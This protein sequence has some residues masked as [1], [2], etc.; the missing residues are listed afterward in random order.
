VLATPNQV[1]QGMVLTART[2]SAPGNSVAFSV[3]TSDAATIVAT[4]SGSTLS[5]GQDAAQIAPG[6]VVTI[7]GDDLSEQT[8]SAD[9]SQR[10]LPNTLAGVQVYF[11][12]IRAPLIFVSPTQIN[13]QVPFEVQDRTSITAYVR[14]QRS[15]GSVTV[16]TPVAVT[17]VLQNPGIFAEGGNDPRPGIVLHGSSAATGTVS[18]DGS[19]KA[20]DTGTV[21]IE[22]RSY[23]YT[24][25][26]RDTLASVRDA[27]INLIN[28]DGK[29]SA[30]AAGSFTR[31]RLRA[32][33]AGEVGIGVAYS[34]K[35]NDGG[36]LIMTALGS[37]LCCAN[38]GP[39]T[40][41][42][43][44]LPGETLIVYATGLGLPNPR[45]EVT[46][47]Q[48]RG[49]DTDPVEFVSSLAGGKTANVL[50]ASLKQG[51]VGIYEV[52][53]ELNSDLPTNPFTQ[54]TIAQ[55]IYVSNI[56]TFP[57]FNPRPPDETVAP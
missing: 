26:E 36:Q 8:A 1:L 51:Q 7:I 21:A 37:A 20:G 42:N 48:Y 28:E 23:T 46:G 40:A 47:I 2:G 53:L 6:T 9:L 49:P 32:K 15:N 13:A 45:V 34:A 38:A 35:N 3:T 5:G 4:T 16:T 52:H 19:I 56:I 29:V 10:E 27:L 22:D 57:V 50:L 41:D 17:I 12:G 18:V 33:V 24:V 54:L 39:V 31:I 55:D 44:A 11:D 14:T 30:F 43:P 25:K